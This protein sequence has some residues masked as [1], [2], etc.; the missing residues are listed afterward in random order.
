MGTRHMD[1]VPPESFDEY[2]LIEALGRGSMGQVWLARD[3]LLDRLVAVKF[4][5]ELP[6]QGEVRQR[7]LIEARA[8]ARV[9]HPNIIAIYRIGEIGRR[10]FLI[11]E[12]VP[13]ERLDRIPRPVPAPRLL[14][15]ALGLAR[16]LAAA[17]H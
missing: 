10:P 11:S 2:R 15:I 6:A 1:W 12:Y 16:G 5:S 4:I 3:T 9:Q 7:F 17:H 8:A 14:H 13:G